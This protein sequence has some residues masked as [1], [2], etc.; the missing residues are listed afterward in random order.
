VAAD[1]SAY[2][3]AEVVD[4]SLTPPHQLRTDVEAVVKVFVSFTT[5]RNRANVKFAFSKCVVVCG[6]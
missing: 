5:P 1:V 3:L 6:M 2:L 4:G